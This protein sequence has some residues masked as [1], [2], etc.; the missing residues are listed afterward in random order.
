MIKI[1]R[2]SVITVLLITM[3]TTAV[4][5]AVQVP[6][7]H[8]AETSLHA[9]SISILD[10]IVGLDITKYTI[11]QSSQY[12]GLF[13]NLAQKEIDIRLTSSQG[14]VRALCSYVNYQLQEIYFADKKGQL[15]LKQE[16]AGQYCRNGERISREI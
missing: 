11:G 4:M 3:I 16:T 2:S 14:T 12:D 15:S 6:V 5:C 7:A 8:A 10:E 9:R 13:V 1:S